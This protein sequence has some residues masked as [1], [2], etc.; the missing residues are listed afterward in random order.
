MAIIRRKCRAVKVGELTI[1]GDAPV[2][3]Q[4]MTTTDTGRV[5]LTLAQIGRL[6]QAGCELVRVAVPDR[7]SARSLPALVAKSP[8]PLIA[9]IHFDYRLALEALRSGVPKVRINPGNIGGEEKFRQVIRAAL[10]EGAALR[11]GV[12]A[13]SLDRSLFI[14]YGGATPQALV[15]SA[16]SYLKIVED[17][18][19]ERVVVSIKASDVL[20]TIAVNRLIAPQ[21]SFPL[22]LGVTEAGPPDRGII[23]SC[24]GLSPLLLEGIGDT[25]RVS[26]TGDPVEEIRVAKQILQALNIRVFGPELVSCPTCGR[27]AID[28]PALVGQVSRLL[29]NIKT[30]LTVAVMGCLVNG[31]GEAKGADLGVTVSKQSGYIFR[32]GKIV[33][34]VQRDDIV[35]ALEEELKR[36][37]E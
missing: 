28:L 4:S 6:S 2:L 25:F 33:T 35:R 27:C 1:G 5:D 22:H 34:K 15:E 10:S 24:L 20:T 29:E 7:E 14:K 18:G 3:I 9:D 16:L 21:T 13:G 26:L 8:L 30:P 11:L 23:K 31:P 36:L 12:N 17:E 37:S 32:K 19:F